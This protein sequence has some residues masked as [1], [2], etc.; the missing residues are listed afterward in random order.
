MRAAQPLFAK[1]FW[2]R[3]IDEFKRRSS[4]GTP[5]PCISVT[6]CSELD[7]TVWNLETAKGATTPRPLYDFDSED[8]V[9]DCI[10]MSDKSIGGSSQTNL[11]FVASDEATSP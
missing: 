1:S 6:P 9:R 3:S 8:A 5:P 10:P 2:T 4:I 7:C 11:D